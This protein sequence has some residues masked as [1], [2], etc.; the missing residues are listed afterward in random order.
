MVTIECKITNEDKIAQQIGANIF[1]NKRFR[2]K[3]N[4]RLDK[5]MSP[6]VPWKD[7]YL[8]RKDKKVTAE[9]IEYHSVYARYQYYLHDMSADL[10]GIT[11]RTRTKHKRPTSFWNEA[12][13]M[14]QGDTLA[15]NLQELI[16]KEVRRINGNS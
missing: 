9:G 4:K 2:W 3:M 14:E 16:D 1:E 6:Y 8:D 7:G 10:A 5:L 15:V 12:F 11:N 13:I